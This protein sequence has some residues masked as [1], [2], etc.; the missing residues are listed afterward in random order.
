MAPIYRRSRPSPIQTVNLTYE[1]NDGLSRKRSMLTSLQGFAALLCALAGVICVFAS[2]RTP[3][4]KTYSLGYHAVSQGNENVY[5]TDLSS[6]VSLGLFLDNAVISGPHSVKVSF[7]HGNDC[8]ARVWARLVGDALIVI[9][10]KRIDSQR[11]VGDFWS[12]AVDGSYQ[13]QVAWT[14]C[15]GLSADNFTIPKVLTVAGNATDT[16]SIQKPKSIESKGLWLSSSRFNAG[17]EPTPMQPYIWHNPQVK[18][19]DATL[20]KAFTS[21]GE[22]L[23]SKE[24]TLISREFSDLSN[25]ELVCFVGS[26]SAAAIREAFLSVRQELFPNQRPFKFHYYNV[27][28][29]EKPDYH[30]DAATKSRFRKCKTIL[31]SIDELE[32]A[33]LTQAQYKRQVKSFLSHTVKAIP[34]STFPIW[35]ITV[36]ESPMAA[37]TMCVALIPTKNHPCNDALNE[38]WREGSFP[39]RVKLLDT[40]DVLGPQFGENQNDLIAVIAMRIYTLVG[41]QVAEWRK[42]KQVG[43]MDGLHRNNVVEPNPKE[44]PYD[45][46]RMI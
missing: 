9:P 8:Q 33:P 10:M 37:S 4:N 13:I 5:A 28:S 6:G 34:D 1:E 15:H 17:G 44:V 7:Q 38:L 39:P 40:R 42:A 43:R 45:W 2:Q 35:L 32:D 21:R 18:A 12:P 36:N 16:L 41:Q 19:T 14:A 22:S 11:W 27:T 3:P 25:Y 31:V 20:I 23:I 24:G 46:T 30:W 29:L 26:D